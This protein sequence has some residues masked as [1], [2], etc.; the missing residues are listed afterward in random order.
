MK[1]KQ[2]IS[3]KKLV[4]S[5]WS[6]KGYALMASLKSEV[7]ICHLSVDMCSKAILKSELFINEL[8]QVL[9]ASESEVEFEPDI[10]LEDL[11]LVQAVSSVEEPAAFV[12]LYNIKKPMYFISAWAFCLHAIL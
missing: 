5:N 8:V 3:A 1:R 4:F 6:R 11:L 2:Y 10:L 7:H 9:S 12:F